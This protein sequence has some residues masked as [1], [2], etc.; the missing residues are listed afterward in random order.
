MASHV[1]VV[2]TPTMPSLMRTMTYACSYLVRLHAVIQLMSPKLPRHKQ[3]VDQHM[4]QTQELKTPRAAPVVASTVAETIGN[5]IVSL[6]SAGIL[7]MSLGYL[8]A[9]PARSESHA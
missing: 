8:T 7:M 1:H 2:T 3:A 6:A 9:K 5:I 4:A